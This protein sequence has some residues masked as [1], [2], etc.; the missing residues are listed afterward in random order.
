MF[1]ITL[2]NLFKDHELKLT[3]HASIEQIPVATKEARFKQTYLGEFRKIVPEASTSNE[4]RAP[5]RF[6]P[7]SKD[8]TPRYRNIVETTLPN[9]DDSIGISPQSPRKLAASK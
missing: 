6:S 1:K 9:I 2:V 3:S 8:V 4:A 7:S 5:L